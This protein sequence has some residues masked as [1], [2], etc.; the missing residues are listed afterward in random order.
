[1]A[2]RGGRS[3]TDE[4][5]VGGS[6]QGDRL[7]HGPILSPITRPSSGVREGGGHCNTADPHSQGNHIKRGICKPGVSGSGNTADSAHKHLTMSPRRL[8]PLPHREGILRH[9]IKEECQDFQ[10]G[11]GEG[12]I[13]ANTAIDRY[14]TRA[15]R[16]FKYTPRR[17]SSRRGGRTTPP[18]MAGWA[19]P[20]GGRHDGLI[21]GDSNNGRTDIPN[22]LTRIPIHEVCTPLTTNPGNRSSILKIRKIKRV[23]IPVFSVSA[24]MHYSKV[25]LGEPPKFGGA[26]GYGEVQI[27]R[28]TGLAIK[29]SSSPSCFEH[30][31][32]VTLLAGESSLRARSSIGITGII[33]PVAFS[34]TEHQ[35]VFKA[36]DMDLNVYC[37]KLSS[38]GPPTSN[39]LNAMEHAFIGLGKAVAYLN[40]KC[41][42]THLDIKCGNIF[43]NTKNFVIKDYVIADFS[44]MTLNTNSTVMRAEF[45]IPTGDASNKVLRLSRGA[46]TTIF[47]LVLGHGH[48]QPTEILVDFINN[49]GLARHRG[50]L[51]SDVGVAVDLYALGQVLLELLLTGCLSPRLPVPILRN[52]TY[53][54]YL[55]QVTVEY[56]L[57]LLAYRCAL[58][59]HIFPSSPIT[60]IHGVPYPAV[61]DIASKITAVDHRSAFHAHHERYQKTHRHIFES[62]RV[63]DEYIH[64]FELVAIFCHSD[65]IARASIPVLWT[66]N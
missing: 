2:R 38:A 50:P 57:D 51:D 55:H 37:N 22:T 1:M 48:N 62:V 52:T 25:A 40:T 43:V 47:S 17:M 41:G 19:S 10:A 16:I 6:S 54:Y 5:D 13:R 27:Y 26:G 3:A 46:A 14:F 7:S 12:K 64:L 58:Y 66:S 34:L 63:P 15:R 4:M 33:Y 31:L 42:L 29:T 11:N 28:Q 18:C 45:E 30:E 9:R 35:M 39:I 53:Y 56:A 24:E 21:R 36:Y 49:S 23:T 20:S 61:E 8:R 44:L 59:P 65:P 32:L 60:T